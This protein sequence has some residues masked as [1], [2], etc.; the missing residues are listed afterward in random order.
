MH[1][2]SR[3]SVEMINIEMKN[4]RNFT[5]NNLMLIQANSLIFIIKF[6]CNFIFFSI[7]N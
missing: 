5:V 1:E 7:N 2:T 3:V 4:M 6:T